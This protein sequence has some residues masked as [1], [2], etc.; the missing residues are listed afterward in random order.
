MEVEFWGVR[1][2]M[3]VGGRDYTKYGGH[4]LC[5]TVVEG[6]DATEI[7]ILDAGTGL[8]RF[9]E[10]LMGIGA[11]ESAEL[12]LH[13]LLTHFHLDHIIGLPFFA[14]LY[15]SQT[16]L[17][18]YSSF[19]PAETEKQ[20]A[21]LMGGR[22]FPVAFKET[23]SVK[24]FKKIPDEGLA[25]GNFLV[26]SLALHHPQGSY[27]YRI[28]LGERSL[29]MATDTEPPEGKFDERLAEF[30]RRADCFVGDA[31]FTPEEYSKRQGWGHSTWQ[32]GVALARASRVG[33]LLLSHLS[34]DHSD[35][36]IDGMVKEARGEFRRTRAAREGLRL[37]L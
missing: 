1:G 21:G 24:S 28:E 29:V 2:T 33:W 14:P 22:Y 4:T 9:G 6:V 36:M 8:K 19:S 20:L 37:K 10:K 12:N 11:K 17:T 35:R 3:P 26:R 23:N 32:H 13:L 31:M 25:I 16:R 30:I 7:L 15:A 27:A 18:I 5:A 34:P